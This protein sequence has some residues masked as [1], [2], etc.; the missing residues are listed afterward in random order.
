[1]RRTAFLRVAIAIAMSGCGTTEVI[2][3]PPSA[4][5]VAL[6]QDAR[7]AGRSIAINYTTVIDAQGLPRTVEPLRGRDTPVDIEALD[8]RG[9]TLDLKSGA[10]TTLPLW[11]VSGIS[12]RG[13]G[14][15]RGA[16]IGGG[17]GAV[18]G[19]G[20]IGFA[21]AMGNM[22]PPRQDTPQSGCDADCKAAFA[23]VGLGGTVVGAFVGAL[24]GTPRRFVFVDGP[25]GP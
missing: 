18:F 12:V 25:S 4:A 9:L 1:M 3:R 21:W 19:L 8:A 15:S 20:L 14:R 13:A 2:G 17:I 23:V 16:L 11:A 5:D 24:I 22:E 6:V 10:Q 7:G